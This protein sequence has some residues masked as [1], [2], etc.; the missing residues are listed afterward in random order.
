[1][2]YILTMKNKKHHKKKWKKTRACSGKKK[3]IMM[4]INGYEEIDFYLAQL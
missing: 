2:T 3:T 4:K 1:M